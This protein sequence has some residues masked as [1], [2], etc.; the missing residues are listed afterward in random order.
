V[1]NYPTEETKII[2]LS[3]PIRS[4]FGASQ[5][6]FTRVGKVNK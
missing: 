6:N 1:Y 5:V 3:H 2:Q 4:F